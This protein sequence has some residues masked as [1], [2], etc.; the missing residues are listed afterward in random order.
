MDDDLNVSAALDGTFSLLA[1][2]NRAGATGAD[3]ANALAAL[4]HMDGVLGVLEQAP[5]A[6][7]ADVE[8]LIERRNAA[9]AARDFDTADALRDELA[10][11]GIE[12]LDGRDGVKWRRTGVKA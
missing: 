10:A 4:R 5:Q 6:L 1:E 2:A 3:A 7:D 12:L 11:L 9:R 8:A